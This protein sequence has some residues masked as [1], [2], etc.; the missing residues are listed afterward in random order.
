MAET[1]Q[2]LT[3]EEIA[4]AHLVISGY[5]DSSNVPV[6]KAL[7]KRLLATAEQHAELLADNARLK[8]DNVALRKA[9]EARGENIDK[10]RR[11]NAEMLAVLRSVEWDLTVRC[12]V[13]RGHREHKPD[14]T[15]SA[16]I[17]KAG[18]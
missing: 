14:C 8:T 6:P 11:D 3:A 13:C 1:A 7:F 12:N 16:A 4:H 5:V 9:Y 15:L 2:A 18:G 10:L 17:K